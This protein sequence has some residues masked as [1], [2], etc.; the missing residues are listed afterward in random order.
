MMEFSRYTVCFGDADSGKIDILRQR[1]RFMTKSGAH[2][3]SLM[4]E[5]VYGIST[6]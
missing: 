3:F 6:H 5:N 1:R 2:L 4:M